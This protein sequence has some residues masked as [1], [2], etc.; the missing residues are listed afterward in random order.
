VFLLFWKNQ[1]LALVKR[2]FSYK[3]YVLNNYFKRVQRFVRAVRKGMPFSVFLQMRCPSRSFR[4]KYDPFYH[5]GAIGASIMGKCT[6]LA[7]YA[8]L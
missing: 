6:I 7:A 4:Q 5:A 1:R 3:D 8:C 2:A